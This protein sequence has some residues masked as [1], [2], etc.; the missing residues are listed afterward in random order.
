M[1]RTLELRE[2]APNMKVLRILHGH[3]G[4]VEGVMGL[5]SRF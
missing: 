4:H 2:S 5:E 3:H 1:L